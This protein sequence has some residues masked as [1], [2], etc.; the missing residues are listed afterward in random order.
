M[1][2][3]G[4]VVLRM[5]LVGTRKVPHKVVY[6]RSTLITAERTAGCCRRLG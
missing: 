2:N 4:Q 5:L 1:K 3:P 6:K